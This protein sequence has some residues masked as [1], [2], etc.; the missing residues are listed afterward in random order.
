MAEDTE[1]DND[2]DDE[3]WD[4]G[5][6]FA[7]LIIGTIP[8]AV[9]ALATLGGKDALAAYPKFEALLGKFVQPLG[10]IVPLTKIGSD[11][12][13]DLQ[14]S[15][16]P[17]QTGTA[18]RKAFISAV[19]AERSA[20]VVEGIGGFA[21]GVMEGL[22]IAASSA[23]LPV[24]GATVTIAATIAIDRWWDTSGKEQVYQAFGFE[25]P[26]ASTLSGK[27]QDGPLSGATVFVD[28]NGNGRLD[29]GEPR[30]ITGPDGSYTLATALHGPIVAQG[31][32]DVTTGQQFPGALTLH[33]GQ[34][35]VS[36]LT[37][38][39]GFL[40]D[41]GDPNANIDTLKAFGLPI[42]YDLGTFDPMSD[43]RV[44]GAGAKVAVVA[45]E[46]ESLFAHT[47][48]EGMNC[49]RQFMTIPRDRRLKTR[50]RQAAFCFYPALT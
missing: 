24:V 29:P 38:I 42:G 31:G 26:S 48:T 14:K 1:P 21:T 8:A 10:F 41:H 17:Y 50:S 45:D 30:T 43:L 33:D 22:G 44:Y 19:E 39:S 18:V 47:E 28:S 34:S 25:E 11:L 23:A 15:Q 2:S 7:G 36:P 9:A 4:K 13:S 5:Q 37:T 20:A 12:Y 46:I 49:R 35:E 3:G 40:E 32:R 27:A 16:T 6:T